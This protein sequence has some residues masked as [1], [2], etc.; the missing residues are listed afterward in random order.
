MFSAGIA[1]VGA[2]GAAGGAGAVGVAA[3]SGITAFSAGCVVFSFPSPGSVACAGCVSTGITTAALSFSGAGVSSAQR[4][5]DVGCGLGGS[6][7]HLSRRFGASTEGVTLSPL[8]AERASALS[9]AAGL[10]DLPSYLSM[11]P[12]GTSNAA[13]LPRFWLE[14]DYDP[15][16]RD[17]DVLK[18]IGR[19]FG[20][21]LCL[22]AQV[23]RP[24]VVRVGDAVRLVDA[25]RGR[26]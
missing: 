21:K 20:G 16:T 5:L 1:A 7:R 22:N 23:L 8:L 14:A 3:S 15:I 9:R 19:R 11:V 13:A 18:D 12:A 17:P 10:P 25:A 4:V 6:S 24:G 26:G 2:A